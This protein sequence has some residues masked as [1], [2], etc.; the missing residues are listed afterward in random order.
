M[1]LAKNIKLMYGFVTTSLRLSMN[2]NDLTIQILKQPRACDSLNLQLNMLG[3]DFVHAQVLSVAL[4]DRLE[5]NRYKL[6]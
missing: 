3:D 6:L 5:T 1:I 2:M 4:P